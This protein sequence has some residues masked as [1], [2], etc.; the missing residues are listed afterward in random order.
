MTARRQAMLLAASVGG[1]VAEIDRVLPAPKVVLFSGHMIDSPDRS[2]PRFPESSVPEVRQRLVELLSTSDSV[3]G[4]TSAACGADLV[5]LDVLADELAG[6][7]EAHVVL[8][9][10]RAEFR[11]LSVE[12]AGEQWTQQ[13]DQVCQRADHAGRLQVLSPKKWGAVPPRSSMPCK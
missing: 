1:P 7:S 10:G 5:F 9:F 2:E 3:I 4:I 8:P 6:R 12:P 11:Q 13:F